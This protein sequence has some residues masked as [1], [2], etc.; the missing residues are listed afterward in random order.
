MQP[1]THPVKQAY[2]CGEVCEV[3]EECQNCGKQ[4]QCVTICKYELFVSL[5]CVLFCKVRTEI[6]RY[7]HCCLFCHGLMAISKHSP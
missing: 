4:Q 7:G 1:Q 3:C 6:V 2:L 5:E